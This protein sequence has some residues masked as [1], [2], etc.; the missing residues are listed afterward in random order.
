MLKLVQAGADINMQNKVSSVIYLLLYQVTVAVPAILARP[1]I[2][3]SSVMHWQLQH[4]KCLG[5]VPPCVYASS[6]E[7][8]FLICLSSNS[9]VGNFTRYID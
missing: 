6:I 5:V 3:S 7:H 2:H 1:S 9:F 8:Q 4:Q